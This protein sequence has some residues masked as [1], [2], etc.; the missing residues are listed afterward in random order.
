MA[1]TASTIRRPCSSPPVSTVM[2]RTVCAS[3]S[4][5]RST[6]PIW[7]DASPIAVATRPSMPGRLARR[8]R[9]TSEYCAW[10][11]VRGGIVEIYPGAAGPRPPR[12]LGLV[13]DPLGGLDGLLGVVGLLA[14]AVGVDHDD[15]HRG[16]EGAVAA[17]GLDV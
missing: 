16:A 8:T 1:S 14:L 2:S 7:P 9:S 11:E 4:W 6:V 5:T 13:G 10:V 17:V 15:A 3:A 12:T